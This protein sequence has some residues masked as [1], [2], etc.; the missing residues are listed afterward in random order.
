MTNIRDKV[1]KLIEGDP[2]L[3]LDLE[4]NLINIRALARYCRDIGIEG[5]EDAIISAIRRYP[6]EQK[7]KQQYNRAFQVLEKSSISTKSNVA[8]MAFTKNTEVQQL[9]P[10]IFEYINYERGETL[11]LTQGDETIRIIIDEKNI[12]KIQNII[13]KKYILEIKKNL[14]EVNIHLHPSTFET[15]GVG[16]VIMG[17]IAREDI[18]LFEVITC[19]PEFLIFVEQR[20]LLDVYRILFKLC[21]SKRI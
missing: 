18:N 6:K 13:P 17:E 21:N 10:K 8:N 9:L 16:Y 20:K 3:K 12:Q 19:V 5:G 15:P 4:R 1:W 14:G 7:L 11:R 2:S